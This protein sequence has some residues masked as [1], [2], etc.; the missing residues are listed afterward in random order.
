MPEPVATISIRRLII[1]PAVITLAVTLLRLVGELQHWSPTLFSREAGGAGAIVG[2]VWLVPI[3]GIYFAIR[4]NQ[5]GH[6][7]TTRG[8]A[9]G[10]AVVALL[11]E[12]ALVFA[13]FKLSLPIVAT[14][15]LT[16]LASF[17]PLWIAYRGWPELGKVEAIYGLAARIPVALL[18]FVAM[19]ANW[20]THY[21]LGPP[22]FPEMSL[23]PKWFVIGLLPQLSLWIA[24]TVIVGS[25]FGSMAL[26]F[27]KR[28]QVSESGSQGPAARGLG[29]HA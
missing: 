17:I 10:F 19:A 9:I 15:V 16:N 4:L 21:E 18:M 13:I 6:G 14:I 1:V 24:F 22:G 29:A 27:Q 28:R 25:L 26:F 23:V 12:A 3:F 8:R 11:A 5:A 20:G 7:P 2:I